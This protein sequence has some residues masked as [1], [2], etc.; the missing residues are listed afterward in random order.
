MVFEGFY[1]EWYRQ[2]KIVNSPYTDKDAP[3]PHDNFILP[4]L[5]YRGRKSKY[6][7]ELHSNAH[8]MYT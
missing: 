5:K 8:T 6:F 4:Y 3:F 7:P 1:I 2:N